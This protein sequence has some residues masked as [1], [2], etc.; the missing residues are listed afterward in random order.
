MNP[1][2]YMI[3]LLFTAQSASLSV[4]DVACGMEGSVTLSLFTLSL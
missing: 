4:S 3:V 1:I 2:V